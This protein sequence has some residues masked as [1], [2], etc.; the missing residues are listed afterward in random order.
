MVVVSGGVGQGAAQRSKERA[1]LFYWCVLLVLLF[2]DGPLGG[3][4]VAGSSLPQCGIGAVEYLDFASNNHALARIAALKKGLAGSS[5]RQS[6]NVSALHK[7]IVSSDTSWGGD[8][9]TLLSSL[10]GGG[11]QGEAPHNIVAGQSLRS[12]VAGGSFLQSDV[13][14]AIHEETMSLD[15]GVD[16]GL[17]T[18]LSSLSGSDRQE[19]APRVNALK[20]ANTAVERRGRRVA[21]TLAV[22]S[23]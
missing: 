12:R 4:G 6:D 9:P 7:E 11:R 10:S 13:C 3:E 15:M 19:S 8:C 14:S 1:V 23:K 5:F 18:L 22:Y 17:S 2:P 16:G 20:R 21:I